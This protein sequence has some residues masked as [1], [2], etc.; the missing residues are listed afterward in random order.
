MAWSLNWMKI[1]SENS[2]TTWYF[3][4]IFGF[5]EVFESSLGFCCRF[6][7]WFEQTKFPQMTE[8]ARWFVRH[9]SSPPTTNNYLNTPQVVS[10]FLFF[11][12]WNLQQKM[13]KFWSKMLGLFPRPSTIH[14]K[15]FLACNQA[16]LITKN[17]SSAAVCCF[18]CLFILASSIERCMYLLHI[19]SSISNSC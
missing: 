17:V 18:S 4:W 2:I 12:C 14:F 16:K 8:V 11:H 7:D 15:L 13:N 10:C 5:E 3:F 9:F 19:S 6:S 1:L